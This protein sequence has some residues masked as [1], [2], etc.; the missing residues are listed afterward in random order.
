MFVRA[1]LTA[2]LLGAVLLQPAPARAADQL[3]QC[4]GVSPDQPNGSALLDVPSHGPL[5]Q[6]GVPEAQQW[7]R[8]HGTQPGAGVTVAVV[9]SGV[10]GG[11]TLAPGGASGPPSYFHGTA[12]AGIIAGAAGIAPA[13]KVLDLRVYTGGDTT[14]GTAQVSAAGVRGAF[15]QLVAHPE[16]GVS[17]VNASLEIGDD[18]GL[19]ADVA[20]LT[21]RGVIVVA[22]TGNRLQASGVPSTY[23]GGED[24][25]KRYF[26]AGYAG[27]VGVSAVAAPG[28]DTASA[29]VANSATDVSAP[30][31]GLQT[32]SL[33]GSPCLV[34][35]VATS[36]ATA[37]VSGV[38]ALLRSAYP[39][40]SAAELIARLEDTASGRADVRTAFAGAGTVQAYEALTR[41]LTIGPTG[42]QSTEAVPAP[43]D[44]ASVPPPQ[45]DVL[46]GTRHLSVWWGLLG[47]GVLLLA[48]VL[49]PVLTRRR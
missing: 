25:A 36:W 3:P 45:P 47:G 24:F 6:I 2:A 26:P 35:G 15:D 28:Q 27:V 18:P 33:T 40:A 44:R 19:A 14:G 4:D 22:S 11:V 38:L 31:D 41:P 34:S 7:L 43:D 12:V 1:A 46:A 23:I 21:K 13:A 48:L 30:T 9:D 16:W 20:T 29:V 32:V 49:R 8:Q 42:R 5:T 17:I 39:H 10:A 37:E